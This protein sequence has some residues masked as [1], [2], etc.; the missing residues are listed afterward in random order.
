M[1]DKPNNPEK[2]SGSP[3][4]WLQGPSGIRVLPRYEQ[5]KD[6]SWKMLNPEAIRTLLKT[7]SR[8]DSGTE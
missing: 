7:W 4:M 2:L 1:S 8:K 6:G 5:Q 3:A